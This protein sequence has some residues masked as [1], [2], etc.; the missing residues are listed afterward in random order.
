MCSVRILVELMTMREQPPEKFS[1]FT[2]LV[3]ASA[4][5]GCPVCRCV[6]DYGRR[7]LGTLLYEQVTDPVTRSRL[8]DAW[9]FCNWHAWMLLEIPDGAFGTAILYHDIVGMALER[10]SRLGQRRLPRR[11][12]SWL[13]RLERRIRI[14][15]VELYRHRGICPACEQ[16]ADAERRCLRGLFAFDH[17]PQLQAAYSRSDGLCVP[18]IISAIELGGGH[19]GVPWL[20]D[21]T[22]AKWRRLREDLASF[23]AK[24][25]HRNRKPYT[26]AD[27]TSY[28]RAVELMVGTPRLFGNDL[29][30][31]AE[32][33]PRRLRRAPGSLA[34]PTEGDP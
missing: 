6:L 15:V 4:S 5:P 19:P 14:A 28:R 3:E 22:L 9:G 17:D 16:A 21:V 12:L 27:A 7:Y 8:R 32:S 31:A 24:H 33:K 20:I 26:E 23:E 10:V 2:R 25:D 11:L 34:A 13:T 18:H 29:H 1:D 30:G